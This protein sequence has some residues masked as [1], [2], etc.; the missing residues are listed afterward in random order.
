[1][2]L[3][4]AEFRERQHKMWTSGDWPELAKTIQ[5]VSDQLVERLG[6]REGQDMLDNGT[7]SGNAAI[8]AAQRGAKV[9][10]SDI[11]PEFFETGRARAKEAGVEIDW[12]EADAADL[13]FEDNSFDAVTSVFGCMFAPVHQQAADELARVTRPGGSFGVCAWTPEGLNGQMLA[14]L[15]SQLPPPPPEAQ[16]PILWGAEAHV[17]E[18]FDGTGV[19]L[20]FEKAHAAL[21]E[22]EIELN[23]AE[24][25]VGLSE[26]TLGPLIAAKAQLEP[27]GKWDEARA[28][29]VELFAAYEKDGEFNP[30]S[31]YLRTVGR[32]V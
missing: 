5:P 25:W 16:P 7:G 18:L 12:V 2:T 21:A 13:P 8:T 27:E 31:E 11:S 22:G 10:G 9:I 30:Q 26:A 19:E 6:I 1:M 24:D 28:R 23:S 4:T 20:E 14:M 17:R 32:V 15:F 29:V 3:D